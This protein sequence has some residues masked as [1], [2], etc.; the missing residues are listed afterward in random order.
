MAGVAWVF[1]GAAAVALL[2][3]LLVF[4]VPLGRRGGPSR[5]APG[6]GSTAPVGPADSLARG[7]SYLHVSPRT[8]VRRAGVHER[9]A[10]AFVRID[11]V[12]PHEAP[13]RIGEALLQAGLAD[14]PAPAPAVPAPAARPDAPSRTDR[15]PSRPRESP[16]E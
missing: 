3:A 12:D 13:R 14:T 5:G 1:V 2:V 10:R 9:L 16:H 7:F 15:G 6:P 4:L 8:A 11:A